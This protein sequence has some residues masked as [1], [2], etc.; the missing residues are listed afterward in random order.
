MT[1]SGSVLLV[2]LVV[3]A[4]MVAGAVTADA[5][6]ILAVSPPSGT[7]AM[8][9]AFDLTLLVAA[10]GLTIVGGSA[11]LDG[12]NV[13]AALAGC[14]IP[15]TLVVGGQTFRCSGVR[16]SS[17][18]PGAHILTITLNFSDGSAVTTAVTWNVLTVTG[19]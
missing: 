1:R 15:G 13:T 5:T 4:F 10:P 19:P 9:Q 3:L 14:V 8:T 12:V 18:G 7:Y 17:L 16:A 2:A 11:V 6:P